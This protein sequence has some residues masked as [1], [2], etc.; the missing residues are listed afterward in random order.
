MPIRF[1]PVIRAGRHGH[2][3]SPDRSSDQMPRLRCA[4]A[5]GQA[6]RLRRRMPRRRRA[7]STLPPPDRHSTVPR[8]PGRP[9]SSLLRS[10]AAA[11]P[12]RASDRTCAR[13]PR[14]VCA[15]RAQPTG[16][17]APGSA[18]CVHDLAYL[19]TLLNV[20]MS[21]LSTSSSTSLSPLCCSAVEHCLFT[22][23]TMWLSSTRLSLVHVS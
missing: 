7:A 6:G 21:R 22:I 15:R 8:R 23:L 5:S 11:A 4:T 13:G 1:R 20:S 18:F 9:G 14:S 10:M 16:P 12:G 3:H 2:S 17:Q 19:S